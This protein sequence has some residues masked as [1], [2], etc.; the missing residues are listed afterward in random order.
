MN[1]MGDVGLEA[2]T[3]AGENSNFVVGGKMVVY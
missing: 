2:P 1:G 3:Y